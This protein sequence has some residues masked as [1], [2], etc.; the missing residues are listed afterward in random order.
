MKPKLER[1]RRV[2]L[3]LGLACLGLL[4]SPLSAQQ[5]KLRHTLKGHTDWVFSVAYSPDGKTL[6]SGSIDKTITLWDVTTGK[7]RAT[8]KGHTVGVLSVAYSPDGKTL[9]SGSRDLTIKLWDMAT[10][11]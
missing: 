10:G 11:K 1:G 6:A 4:L 2:V 7:E 9:A 8:L 3:W 5:P